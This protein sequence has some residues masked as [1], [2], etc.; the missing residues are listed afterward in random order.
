MQ[1]ET[2]YLPLEG[3]Y[4]WE[5]EAPDRVYM[6][7]PVG[8]GEVEEYTWA[9]TVDQGRRMAAHLRSLG[10][11]RESSIAIVSK[12]CAHFILADLAIWMAGYKSVAL[13]PTLDAETAS[14]VLDHS[15]AKLLFVGKLDVWDE[16]K[17]GVPDDLPRIAFPLSP[18]NDYPKWNDIVAAN[19]PIT[20]SPSRAPEETALLCYT[21][22]STGKPKGVITTFGN[23]AVAAK[24]VGDVLETRTDDRQ[25]S[26]L[27]LAHSFERAAVE[28][29]SLHVGSQVY[30][31]ESLET[32]VD[33][34]RRARPTVFHSVPRLWLKFQLGVLSK[35][36]QKKLD[37][38]L[39][40][41]ILRNVVRA[42]ILDGLGLGSA[43]LAIS[44]SAP[45]PAELITWY[46]SLGLELLEGYA[47]TENFA[48]SHI[49][50]PGKTRAGYVGNTFPGVEC[51][52]SEA[53]E[54]LVKSDATMPGYF[55][56]PELTAA[57]FTEDGFLK[58]GDRGEID[59]RGRLKI[60]GRVKELF[61]TS[62][63]KYIAPVPIEN[64]LNADNHIEQSC[65]SGVG[66]PQPYAVAML[67]ED[68]RDAIADPAARAQ[69]TS[70]LE[71]LLRKVN[72]Q[73]ASYERLEFIAIA[74][75]PWLIE[76][77]FL[78]PTMKIKRKVL[79]DTYGPQLD[80]WYSA[81]Q[82]VV[83]EA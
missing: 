40:I 6:V 48:Y 81:K 18:P 79:E 74:K 29:L 83:W 32:F 80:V 31:A 9:Q 4:R 59:E 77:G 66:H 14:Y 38:L 13:Y 2:K 64:L 57:C 70:G 42:K 78:T 56:A 60:T 43:R 24:G 22:G 28:N 10:L 23:M 73:V 35:M 8:G 75:D 63:G 34:L 46:R 47:M 53:G 27:P 54:V 33:D 21:S 76:N 41:P 65:V 1:I 17:R 51:K 12:N 20:N 7:Q 50:M 44:G 68:L 30:F 69:V 11:P 55:K 82:P 72:E 37:R 25:L 26:Y 52:V 3:A 39:K 61:K 19:E 62:K 5:R 58:T 49:N 36:P 45:I 67:S 71:A 15:E 16:M